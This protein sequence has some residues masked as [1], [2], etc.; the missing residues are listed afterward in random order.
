MTHVLAVIPARGGSKGIPRKNLVAIGGVPLVGRSVLAAK[1][2]PAVTDVVVSTDD[3]EIASVAR[4]YGA[5]VID[6]PAEL[7]SDTA[8]SESAL[9]HASEV[10]RQREGRPH[11]VLLLVQCTSPFHDP[12][13][14]QAV[15]ENVASGKHNSCIT[16]TET[17]QYFWTPGPAGWQM[18]YQQRGRRQVRAP[19]FAEAGSLYCV[20]RDLFC[21]DLNLFVPPLGA[22]VIPAW[23]AF[24]LDE[25]A[26]ITMAELIRSTFEVQAQQTQDRERDEAEP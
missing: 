20:R 13:D 21:T 12:G 2:C 4:Q 11:D 3:A 16:V 5:D 23:R 15:I 19:W 7:A 8:S 1:R 26:D 17:Y 18:R 9:R 14:M 24:E 22:H 6:R 10:W 25:P